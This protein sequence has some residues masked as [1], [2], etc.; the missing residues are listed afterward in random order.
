MKKLSKDER[1]G[2]VALAVVV[3]IVIGATAFFRACRP[4]SDSELPNVTLIYS[5]KD[6]TRSESEFY[7]RKDNP[8][9]RKSS[10]SRERSKGKRKG[11][12][13]GKASPKNPATISPPRDFL[14]DT[15]PTTY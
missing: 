1:K 9:Y 14:S 11:S 15:I 8:S 10:K 2:A 4:V 6:S 7:D 12:S 5:D 13:R 3:V